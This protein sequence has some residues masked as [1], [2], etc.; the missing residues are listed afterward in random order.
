[1]D[2]ETLLLY[3]QSV[4]QS[5]KL[6]QT[7]ALARRLSQLKCD[8][9]RENNRLE[10]TSDKATR[11]D[12][13]DHLKS[14]PSVVFQMCYE[15]DSVWDNTLIISDQNGTNFKSFMFNLGTKPNWEDIVFI[16]EI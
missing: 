7:K 9:T 11:I 13:K 5:G 3:F 10:A 8:L 15:C 16:E 4:A 14:M 1:M 12:I 6:T 2:P